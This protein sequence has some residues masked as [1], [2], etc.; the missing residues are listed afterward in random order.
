MTQEKINELIVKELM[1]NQQMLKAIIILLS[2]SR[3]GG[4]EIIN[5]CRTNIEEAFKITKEDNNE[6]PTNKSN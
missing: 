2:P 1:V 3:T 6:I 4:I 5:E